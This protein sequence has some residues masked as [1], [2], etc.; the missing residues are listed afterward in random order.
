ML[1]GSGE[2]LFVSTSG[3]VRSFDFDDGCEC[4]FQV[5]NTIF[6][7]SYGEIKV[8]FAGNIVVISRAFFPIQ[9][10][11]LQDDYWIELESST[12]LNDNDNQNENLDLVALS[13]DGKSI[14]VAHKNRLSSSATSP[15]QAPLPYH[16]NSTFPSVTGTTI[17]EHNDASTGY[18]HVTLDGYLIMIQN[19]ALDRGLLLGAT[20]DAI[21]NLVIVSDEG[22]SVYPGLCTLVL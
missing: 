10:L 14:F 22:T 4:W 20:L 1:S 5:G 21:G 7:A 13:P 17:P 8:S 6:D 11:E 2:R 9:L 12:L 3:A 15:M 16:D 18:M 19:F